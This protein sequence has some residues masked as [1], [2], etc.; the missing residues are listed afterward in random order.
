[1]A[2]I[3]TSGSVS[4]DDTDSGTTVATVTDPGIYQFALDLSDIANGETLIA[5][6]NGRIRAADTQRVFYKNE[7][8]NVQGPEVN[9]L[10]IPITAAHS[11]GVAFTLDTSGVSA[12]ITVVWAVYQ[13]DA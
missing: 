12:S 4:I 11:G 10:S 5:A 1:M 8:A 13:L 6:I 2:S 3:K 7:F 9:K